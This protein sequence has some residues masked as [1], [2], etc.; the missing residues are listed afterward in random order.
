MWPSPSPTQGKLTLSRTFETLSPLYDFT[1]DDHVT[2][3]IPAAVKPLPENLLDPNRWVVPAA[4]RLTDLQADLDAVAAFERWAR[5]L[6]GVYEA[7][8]ALPAI[9]DEWIAAVD[10]AFALPTMSGYGVMGTADRLRAR[11]AAL[12][13]FYTSGLTFGQIADRT[14]LSVEDVVACHFSEQQ[15]PDADR[16]VR[17]ELALLGGVLVDRSGTD[18]AAEFGVSRRVLFAMADRH[19]LARRTRGCAASF[20]NVAA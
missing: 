2:L 9:P 14:G 13:P 12:A 18:V 20:Q 10:V 3:P 5:E 19:G 16:Y 1:S 7:V 17:L 8:W 11:K 6:L 4:S 15:R